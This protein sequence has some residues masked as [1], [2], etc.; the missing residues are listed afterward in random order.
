G[1]RPRGLAGAG[2]V[3]RRDDHAARPPA[4][5]ARG[6]HRRSQ[7]DPGGRGPGERA[8]AA[9][10]VVRPEPSRL[11]WKES[12]AMNKLS[13]PLSAVAGFGRALISRSTVVLG[14]LV[15]SPA[16]KRVEGAQAAP[17]RPPAPVSVAT[18]VE[19][20]VPVYLDQIGRNAAP[21]GVTIQPQDSGRVAGRHGEE[22][23]TV[24]R[25]GLRYS[26]E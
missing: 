11:E 13:Q 22:G 23:D 17:H 8:R 1:R 3:P 21:E 2:A 4:G 18:A 15:V 19:Q 24:V 16:C 26:V 20:D 5:A 9:A 14:L 6:L 7:P 25:V 10:P 12:N